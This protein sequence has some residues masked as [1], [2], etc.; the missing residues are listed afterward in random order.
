M[1]ITRKRIGA[2]F[3]VFALVLAMAMSLAFFTDREEASAS[4]VAG[5]LGLDLDQ[6]WVA[7]NPDSGNLMPGDIYTLDY[8]LANTG[9]KSADVREFFVIT[10]DVDLADT[11]PAEFEVYAVGD[12]EQDTTSG[13]YSPKANAQPLT[14]RTTGS[15]DVTAAGPDGIE[16]NADDVATTYYTVKYSIPEFILNGDPALDGA[17]TETGITSHFKE[18]SYVILFSKSA[19]NA[20]QGANV[21]IDYLAEAKQHRNTDAT[22]WDLIATESIQFAGADTNVVPEK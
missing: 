22:V 2:L 3:L 21:T 17:E 20:F 5:T 16:G 7:D 13:Y 19:T 4:A 12:V 10:S 9:N 18:G 14:V 6:D 11:A 8:T 15:Y 1:K